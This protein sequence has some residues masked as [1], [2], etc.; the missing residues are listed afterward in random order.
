MSIH[1]LYN[2]LYNVIMNIIN[3]NI[4][5]YNILTHGKVSYNNERLTNVAQ[6]R[7]TVADI[8]WLNYDS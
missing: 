6:S 1:I 7:S 3:H 8:N 4:V 5:D 2:I